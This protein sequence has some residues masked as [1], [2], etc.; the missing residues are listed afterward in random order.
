M[1]ESFGCIFYLPMCYGK[2]HMLILMHNS[3]ASHLSGG[4]IAY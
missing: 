2:L 4:P 3:S 1:G